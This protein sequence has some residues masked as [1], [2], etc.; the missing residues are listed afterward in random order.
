MIRSQL[1]PY[2]TCP[3]IV[4]NT[5]LSIGRH[6]LSLYV[7]SSQRHVGNITR[8]QPIIYFY[9][10]MSKGNKG[11]RKESTIRG[12][13]TKQ[14]QKQAVN[15]LPSTFVLPCAIELLPP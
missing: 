9:N 13:R 8:K 10:T 5:F 2:S 11:R 6:I 3:F 7:K 12:Q 15:N 4:K 1:R 14:T